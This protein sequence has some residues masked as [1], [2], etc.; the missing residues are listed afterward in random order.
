VFTDVPSHSLDHRLE[1]DGRW[2]RWVA[3][4]PAHWLRIAALVANVG[5]WGLIISV[6][7]AV[8]R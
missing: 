7:R 2:L 8:L 4:T 5:L 6:L 1:F 3:E